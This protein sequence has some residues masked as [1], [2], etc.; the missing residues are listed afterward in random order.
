MKRLLALLIGAAITAL[1]LAGCSGGS[2]GLTV[3]LS[4][5]A[6]NL[7][8]LFCDSPLADSA[9]MNCLEGLL[10]LGEDGKIEN[11]CSEGHTISPDGL[12]YTFT[13]KKGLTWSDGSPLISDDFLYTFE[14]MF[15]SGYP[16]A[17]ATQFTCIKNASAVLGGAAVSSLGV[18]TPDDHTIIFTLERPN[19]LFEGLIAS[20]GALPCSRKFFTSTGGK[21]GLGKDKLLYNGAFRITYLT[22][23]SVTLRPNPAYHSASTVK[24][25]VVYLNTDTAGSGVRAFSSGAVDVCVYPAAY[26]PLMTRTDAAVTAV[27]AKTY[28]VLFNTASNHFKS[29]SL[30]SA[31]M[32][33]TDRSSIDGA[34]T[35]AVP[36]RS[37]VP[38]GVSVGTDLYSKLVAGP[39]FP[40]YDKAGAQ[41][42][43]KS[44]LAELGL[45]KIPSMDLLV[46]EGGLAETVL[47]HILQTWQKDLGF[48]IN[49]VT[50]SPTRM[51]E[52]IAAGTYDA[53]L[54]P[55]S[56]AYDSPL[57]VL[58]ELTN[59]GVS[60]PGFD[61]ALHSAASAS[62]AATVAA[63][64]LEAE[65]LLASSSR[66]IPIF[67][68][69]TSLA[70]A[71]SVKGLR[72][73]ANLSYIKFQS[74]VK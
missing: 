39:A 47:P 51:R 43:Y 42:D 8:P 16:S 50:V 72:Y 63:A 57:S 44:A 52:M 60:V 69:N 46:E 71:P 68:E 13:L 9:V 35:G 33:D 28:S 58:S 22:D 40:D 64:C 19:A 29:A 30:R 65:R 54:L 37:L 73:P 14:R 61:E 66:I 23:T 53:V 36:A 2:D 18:S 21:Y 74:A 67:C 7:D 31:L 5:D 3:Y 20:K 49:V 11:G 4:G 15:A 34:V 48:Y 38:S 45:N 70:A 25:T 41:A 27:G 1:L 56:A 26:A 62:S 12:V 32:K 10:V 17:L 24:P 6:T 59:Y 55:L